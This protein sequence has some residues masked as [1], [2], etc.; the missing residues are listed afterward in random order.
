[1]FLTGL[2]KFLVLPLKLSQKFL[3]IKLKTRL[4]LCL[5]LTIH[6]EIFWA[7]TIRIKQASSLLI[8]CVNYCKLAK[9]LYYLAS[10]SAVVRTQ[11]IYLTHLFIQVNFTLLVVL[12]KGTLTV[13]SPTQIPFTVLHRGNTAC[14]FYTVSVLSNDSAVVFKWAFICVC[15]CVRVFGNIQCF[16]SRP[17]LMSGYF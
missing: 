11:R 2:R 7:L 6:V 16:C 14:S 17:V 8:Y 12:L 4:I 3:V 13:P 1:M 9:K 10:R 15:V 5:T